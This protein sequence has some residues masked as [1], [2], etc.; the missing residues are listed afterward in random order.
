M[1]LLF[2]LATLCSASTLFAQADFI[3][4]DVDGNQVVNGQDANLLQ[5]H[6]F[7]SVPIQCMDAA[8]VDDNGALNILDLNTLQ[9]FINTGNPPMRPPYPACGQDPTG[10]A[11]NCVTGCPA[12]SGCDTLCLI[13]PSF[14][15]SGDTAMNG[16]HYVFCDFTIAQGVDVSVNGACTLDVAGTFLI[17]SGASLRSHCTPLVINHLQDTGFLAIYGEVTDTCATSS[18]SGGTLILRSRGGM[19]LGGETSGPTA[20]ITAADVFIGDPDYQALFEPDTVNYVLTGESLMTDL[21]PLCGIR[22]SF[23]PPATIEIE[24]IQLS[25]TSVPMTGTLYFG[26][27]DSLINPPLTLQYTYPIAGT[28]TVMYH[29]EDN[30]GHFTRTSLIAS[31]PSGEMLQGHVTPFVSSSMVVGAGQSGTYTGEAPA[32]CESSSWSFEGDFRAGPVANYSWLTPAISTAIFSGTMGSSVREILVPVYVNLE[33]LDAETY[34]PPAP[35]TPFPGCG[36]PPLSLDAFSPDAHSTACAPCSLCDVPPEALGFPPTSSY[37]VLGDATVRT[38]RSGGWVLIGF[39]DATIIIRSGFSMTAADGADGGIGSSGK[40]GGGMGLVTLEGEVIECGGSYEVGSG[41]DGGDKDVTACPADSKAGR[42]GD[43]G[44]V[45]YLAP[46]G[47]VSWCGAISLYGGDGGDGGNASATG[48][49]AGAC[50]NGCAATSR[51]GRGG[52]GGGGLSVFASAICYDSGYSVTFGNASSGGDGGAAVSVA[53]DG[54]NCGICAFKAGDGG[55]AGAYGGKGGPAYFYFAMHPTPPASL[56]AGHLISAGSWDGGDGADADATAGHGGDAL[57]DCCQ[58]PVPGIDG[59]KGGDADAHGGR[60]GRGVT[61][62]GV[63]G[64]GNAICGNGGDGMDGRPPGA[65]GGGAI[66]HDD[67]EPGKPCA[68]TP[69]PPGLPGGPC[70]QNMPWNLHWPSLPF[71]FKWGQNDTTGSGSIFEGTNPVGNLPIKFFGQSSYQSLSGNAGQVP[72]YSQQQGRAYAS[73]GAMSFDLTNLPGGAT[74]SSFYA[75]LLDHSG[76]P[77][78]VHLLG[79]SGGVLVS[80][81]VGSAA[82]EE[83]TLQVNSPPLRGTESA[84]AALDSVVVWGLDFSF[85]G[86]LGLW[87]PVAE[88]GC[89]ITMTGDVNLSGTLTSADIIGMVNYVFK[90]GSTP[91]PCPASGDLNCNG[92]VTSADIITLVNHIFKGGPAPCDACTSP[93]AAGC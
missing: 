19:I 38:L 51:G 68:L 93:L 32:S 30:L 72:V 45:V 18:D 23:L 77:S 69:C 9:S 63:H 25:L 80:Q 58:P 60:R 3:R 24:L 44:G 16:G 46:M 7:I 71:D 12:V 15:P 29:L 70:P 13:S 59:G 88:S 35:G 5:Q 86:D 43:A 20:S 26:N 11:L 78:N 73:P 83:T 40:P 28:Y 22:G 34:Y 47:S 75:E 56:L 61:T 74:T 4:G 92:S 39:E 64:L 41:G 33:G 37:L 6:I 85:V 62:N 27:G 89:P 48:T 8:D 10:D 52:F 84:S 91:L 66:A 90:G 53:T 49:P 82:C 36:D 42:G 50:E 21:P 57:V 1:F 54:G 31:V 67:I 81:Q 2:L 79:Y 87:I 76:D 55:F 17:D 14:A 65:G